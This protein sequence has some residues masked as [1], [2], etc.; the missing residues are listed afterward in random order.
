[1][2]FINFYC[3]L[4]I[5]LLFIQKTKNLKKNILRETSSREAK[6]KKNTRKHSFLSTKYLNTVL[7]NLHNHFI[8]SLKIK[9]DNELYPHN[10]NFN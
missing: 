5:D 9:N 1:M 3:T 6:H 4:S 10:S 7:K 8:V 2:P